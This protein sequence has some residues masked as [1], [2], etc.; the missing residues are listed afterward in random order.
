MKLFNAPSPF[1]FLS[2]PLGA[3]FSFWIPAV[4]DSPFREGLR[5]ILPI[6][7]TVRHIHALRPTRKFSPFPRFSSRTPQ[8]QSPPSLV[9]PKAPPANLHF[10]QVLSLFFHRITAAAATAL[11][12]SYAPCPAAHL[13]IVPMFFYRTTTWP[14][15]DHAFFPPP[16]FGE[17]DSIGCLILLNISSPCSISK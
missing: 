7:L 13:C 8:Q 16:C 15:S 14:G 2:S 3:I 6:P 5:E 4:R 10:P 1:C 9:D 17:G 11:N 12:S